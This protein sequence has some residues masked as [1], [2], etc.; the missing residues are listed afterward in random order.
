MAWPALKRVEN[1][2]GVVQHAD[3]LHAH[4][5]RSI[6][7]IVN[8]AVMTCRYDILHVGNTCSMPFGPCKCMQTSKT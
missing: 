7:Y 2:K 5:A 6:L 3:S 8:P 4:H 1:C